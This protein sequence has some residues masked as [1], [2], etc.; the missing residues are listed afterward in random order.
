MEQLEVEAVNDNCVQ[1]LETIKIQIKEIRSNTME[2]IAIRS[3][4]KWL[5]EGE[6]VS[7]YFCNL[8]SRNFVNKSMSFFRKGEWRNYF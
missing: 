1:H 4:V 8:E 5:Q 2:G 6:K 7:R 3:R